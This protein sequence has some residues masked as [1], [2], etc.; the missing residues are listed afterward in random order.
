MSN[1][2]V[3]KIVSVVCMFLVVIPVAFVHT[4]Q[5]YDTAIVAWMVEHGIMPL[6]NH[7]IT[8]TLRLIIITVPV[9]VGLTALVI[10]AKVLGL[11]RKG[12]GLILARPT[13]SLHTI[14]EHAQNVLATCVRDI[15][16]SAA[17]DQRCDLSQ[18]DGYVNLSF[19]EGVRVRLHPNSRS[20]LLN[21]ALGTD[22]DCWRVL[23]KDPTWKALSFWQRHLL[24]QHLLAT[25]WTS[26]KPR[27]SAHERLRLH[28]HL[29]QQ[30]HAPFS[31][32]HAT[33]QTA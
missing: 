13:L 32:L 18:W 26:Q 16:E 28:Q 31:F 25:T 30:R 7:A 12:C 29:Q 8:S 27:Y 20:L 4:Y 23:R 1:T 33:T 5:H 6:Q 19:S 14:T 24:T 11:Y 2:V 15:L 9:V 10:F 22:A 21:K 17:L 3:V